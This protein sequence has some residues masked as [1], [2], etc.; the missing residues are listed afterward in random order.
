MLRP[1]AFGWLTAWRADNVL[2]LPE[3]HQSYAAVR[4]LLPLENADSSVMRSALLS[5]RVNGVLDRSSTA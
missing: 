3:A 2:E 4:A 5:A 1:S